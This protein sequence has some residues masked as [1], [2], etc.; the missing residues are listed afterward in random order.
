M[1]GVYNVNLYYAVLQIN[2]Q[3]IYVYDEQ[4]QLF[5]SNND[6]PRMIADQKERIRQLEV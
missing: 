1:S 6:T 4:L 2:K 3:L 5:T